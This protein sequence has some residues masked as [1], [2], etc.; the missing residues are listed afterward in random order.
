[1]AVS[2]GENLNV[3]STTDDKATPS[4]GF[5]RRLDKSEKIVVP[6]NRAE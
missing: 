1:M 2:E 6:E 5:E 4:R 3:L